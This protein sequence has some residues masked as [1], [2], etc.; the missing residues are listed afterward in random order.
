VRKVLILGA[1]SFALEA[2]D[3]A[4]DLGW[5]VAGYVVD[6]KAPKTLR[7]KPV[8]DANGELPSLPCVC[9]IVSPERI[10]LVRNLAGRGFKFLTS[11]HPDASVSFASLWGLEGTGSL[12][13]RGAVVSRDSFFGCCVVVNRNASVGHDCTLGECCT[14]GP[15]A[16]LAG[17]V[18]VGEGAVVGMGANV[19]EGV[20]IGTGAV[21][22]M[23]AVVLQDVPDGETWWG[24]PARKANH[25]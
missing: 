14:V 21:V 8:H 20:Q 15:G 9:G 6:V 1:G 19:R 23:G 17:G 4:K 16:N 25:D 11:I 22:G 24:V 12:V 13:N 10:G 3:V 7:G 2:A 5:Q 18:I